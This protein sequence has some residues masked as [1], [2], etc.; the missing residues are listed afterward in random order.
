MIKLKK[1]TKARI[2]F[3]TLIA[4]ITIF[5]LGHTTPALAALPSSEELDHI[6]ATNAWY[7]N[8]NGYAIGNGGCIISTGTVTG[9]T[10]AGLSPLQADFVDKYHS[11]AEQLSVEYGI[12]WETVMAQGIL[13]SAAGTS[14]FAIERNNF[15]GIGAFDSNVNN[16]YSYETPM[17][18]WRGYYEN[19][20][21]TK[22]YRAHGVFT[23]ANITDPYVYLQTIKDSGYATDPNYVSKVSQIIAA[24]ENR[25]TQMGWSS[26]AQL[27]AD[28][29][30]MIANAAANAEGS[31]SGNAP[32]TTTDSN[33]TGVVCAVGGNGD[34][35]QTAIELSWPDRTH[36]PSDAK[37]DYANALAQTGIAAIGTSIPDTCVINGNSCDAFVATVM[38]FSGVDPN[39][40]CCGAANIKN[41]LES[42][43][44]LYEK[45]GNAGSLSS[46]DMAPG[47]IRASTGHVE[48]Y[49]QLDDGSYAIASASHCDRNADHAGRFYQ[50]SA[51]DVYRKK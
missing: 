7:Y 33:I 6:Y 16:A 2:H 47:D 43:S 17:D 45:V 18:G 12:P 29:P 3:I 38:R 40:P 13:E 9:I 10:S 42:H 27:A 34:I 36:E 37:P 44:E 35:N 14:R 11:I 25:S 5:I 20:R 28:Y 8:S 41:Y 15:F 26:S 32:N 39:F 21:K 50:D 24:I 23:G 48:I 4:F 51:F 30:Q 31:S 46:A 1:T 22:T 49:V 19:I